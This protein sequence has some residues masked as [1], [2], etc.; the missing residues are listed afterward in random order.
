M[1]HSDEHDL[2]DDMLAGIAGFLGVRLDRA[3]PRYVGLRALVESTVYELAEQATARLSAGD[4]GFSVVDMADVLYEHADGLWA[5]NVV[6]CIE[7]RD[8]TDEQRAALAQWL[9]VKQAEE[10]QGR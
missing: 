9:E 10:R 4:A 1:Q 5:A 6:E 7:A 2:I 3:R 8:L